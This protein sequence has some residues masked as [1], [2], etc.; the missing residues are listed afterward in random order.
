MHVE[1]GVRLAVPPRQL[2][3]AGT[4]SGESLFYQLLGLRG[5]RGITV[6]SL[7]QALLKMF[8][9]V[10]ETVARER[11]LFLA[12]WP[13]LLWQ[14]RLASQ[15]VCHVVLQPC[16]VTFQ[17]PQRQWRALTIPIP[18][19]LATQVAGNAEEPR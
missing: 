3:Q 14:R 11:E 9:R 7:P 17:A 6:E 12:I 5:L 4:H 2:L 18:R 13:A 19:N 1:K 10:L 8:T 16:E 15:A